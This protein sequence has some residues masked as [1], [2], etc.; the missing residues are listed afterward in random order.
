M[1]KR[2]R[3]LIGNS[4]SPNKVFI[5][6]S[7]TDRTLMTAQCTSAGLFPPSESEIW[8]EKLHWQ[9][10]PVHTTNM[11]RDH[12]LFPYTNCPSYQKL[13]VEYMKSA[14]VTALLNKHKALLEFME[15]NSGTP[16]RTLK[17]VVYLYDALHVE[18]MKGFQ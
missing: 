18:S 2:Y 11:D 12:L 5:Q 8:N 7:D 15:K 1:R 3:K 9:P 6:S 10:T 4:Y 14:E 17:D 13:L 16:I